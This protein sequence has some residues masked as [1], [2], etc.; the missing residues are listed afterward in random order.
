MIFSITFLNVSG[1][2]NFIFSLWFLQYV[3]LILEYCKGGDL[4]TKVKEKDDFSEPT[5]SMIC[6]KIASVLAFAHSKGIMHRDLKPENILLVSRDSDTDIRVADFGS[7]AIFSPGEKLNQLVGSP[8]YIAP[9]VLKHNYGFEADLWSLGVVLYIVLG[10]FPP[11][12]GGNN[13]EIFHNVLND[14]LNMNRGKI[15][16]VSAEGKDLIVRLLNRNVD[17]ALTATEVLGEVFLPCSLIFFRFLTQ[18]FS[19]CL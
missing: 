13:K 4:F 17:E 14:P 12:W 19:R 1:K 16:D 3:H 11:F 5:A 6:R 10:G 2:A 8:L 7:S 15:R 9:S 18:S